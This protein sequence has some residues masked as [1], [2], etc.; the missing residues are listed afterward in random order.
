MIVKKLKLKR[1]ETSSLLSFIQK[2][3]DNSF[4][5]EEGNIKN[6]I[7]SA[8][9]SA[10][11]TREGKIKLPE[12]Y[13][14]VIAKL[15]NKYFGYS[16]IY[17]TKNCNDD[18]NYDDKSS[19]KD[20][21]VEKCKKFKPIIVL[22][23]HGL[24]KKREAQINIGT[25]YGHS[26][27]H[28]SE[29]VTELIHN[30]KK[31]KI[32]KIVTDHPFAANGRTITYNLPVLAKTKA[33]QVEINY[34]FLYKN[35]KNISRVVNS[36][37]DFCKS[38]IKR[39]SIR[40]KKIDIQKLKTIDEKFYNSQGDKDFEYFIENPQIILSAPQAKE[41]VINNSIK[42]SESMSGSICKV[43]NDEFGFSAIFKTRD[44][45]TD[46]FNTLKNPYKDILFKKMINSKTK[47]FLELHI[48][49]GGR[50][51]DVLM[52]LP[53]NYDKYKFYQIINILNNHSITKFSVNSI[54]DPQKK[55][56]T[57]NQIKGKCF[58]LQF[59]INKRLVEKNKDLKNII[60]VLKCIISLFIE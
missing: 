12:T 59:C 41:G 18:V 9:H 8:P 26:V 47:L 13:T 39:E 32:N 1:N 48:I 45:K 60:D 7:I 22:D 51:D 57:I 6:I 34:G 28:D 49:N 58:K 44:N 5:F 55:T 14:G 25:S 53:N 17:K 42:L 29:I 16:I 40:R 11:Q 20:F 38:L 37:N 54:F 35:S 43:L 27:F 10:P 19:Y 33:I 30:F 3:T 31:N 23:L 36:I 15:L 2:G 52:M 56:R 50:D 21:L 4:E 46:Y 24:S